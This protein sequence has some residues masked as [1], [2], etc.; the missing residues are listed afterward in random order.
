MPTPETTAIPKFLGKESKRVGPVALDYDRG[1]FWIH[2]VGTNARLEVVPFM[3]QRDDESL[4]DFIA[5]VKMVED[6]IDA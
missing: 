2:G 1:E 3:L 6:A 4:S 5:R